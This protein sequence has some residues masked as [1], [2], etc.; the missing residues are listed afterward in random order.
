MTS[1]RDRK[2]DYFISYATDDA[3]WAVWLGWIIEEGGRSVILQEW[4]FAPGSNFV[5][6]MDRA[7]RESEHTIA[8]L[9]PNYLASHYTH[10]EWA[11]AFAQDSAGMDKALIPIRVEECVLEGLLAQVVHVDLVG[12]GEDEARAVISQVL[13]ESRMKPVDR[14]AYPGL[15]HKHE[16]QPPPFPIEEEGLLDLVERGVADL[17]RGNCAVLDFARGVEALGD[18]AREHAARFRAV[19]PGATQ[20]Q[21]YRQVSRSAAA[22]MNRF[23]NAGEP[24]LKTMA[25]AYESGFGAWASA[26]GL[27]PEF[28][29]I[30]KEMIRENMRSLDG[31]L[32]SIP[33][34]RKSTAG[35]RDVTARLPRVDGVFATARRRAAEVL[36]R[37][38]RALDRVEFLAKTVHERGQ[39]LVTE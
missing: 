33:T 16:P 38:V 23:S 27:L 35:L 36:D 32:A 19:G 15:V 34:A 28:G 17:R 11:A 6:E 10:P 8:V 12:R 30:D 9:T 13:S 21:A 37:G 1:K 22:A 14:P 24:Q 18:S 3:S 20:L 5:L 31:L 25:T 2:A 29:E 7:A 39:A 4:D 26:M